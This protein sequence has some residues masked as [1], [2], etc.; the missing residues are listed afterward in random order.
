MSILATC[1]PTISRYKEFC[2]NGA[3]KLYMALFTEDELQTIGQHMR[4]QPDIPAGA[5]CTLMPVLAKL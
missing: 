1:A 3:D 2:K 5:S 4:Q